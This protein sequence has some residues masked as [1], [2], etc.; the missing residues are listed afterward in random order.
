MLGTGATGGGTGVLITLLYMSFSF[1]SR[2]VVAF[3]SMLSVF[4]VREFSAFCQ[5]RVFLVFLLT[6]TKQFNIKTR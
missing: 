6:F 3:G 2:L 5:A 1:G 4:I